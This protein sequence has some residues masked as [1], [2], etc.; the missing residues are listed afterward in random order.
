MKEKTL[1]LIFLTALYSCETTQTKIVDDQ[2]N[3]V[4]IPKNVILDAGKRSLVLTNSILFFINSP[5]LNTLLG[6]FEKDIESI[7]SMDIK[8]RN[9]SKIKADL[10][11]EI[12]NNLEDEEYSIKISNNISING[13]SY[14]AL[15]MAKST[16]NQLLKLKKNKLIFF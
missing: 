3:I 11:F 15:A 8:F 10:I 16:L 6:V 4:P 1:I 14:N 13:G 9:T 7:S 12:D 5:E 2:P